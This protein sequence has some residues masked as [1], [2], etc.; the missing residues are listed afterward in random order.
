MPSGNAY[1]ANK[2]DEPVT[3]QGQTFEPGEVTHVIDNGIISVLEDR[4]DFAK[5]KAPK[6]A[7]A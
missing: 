5:A 7:A 1:Y 6:S 3:I 2:G 4:E